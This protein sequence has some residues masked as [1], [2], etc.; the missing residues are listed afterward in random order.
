M[1]FVHGVSAPTRPALSEKLNDPKNNAWGIS[2]QGN[3]S[4]AQH[5][6]I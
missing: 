4:L 5:G 1:K 3:F 6:K 2:N